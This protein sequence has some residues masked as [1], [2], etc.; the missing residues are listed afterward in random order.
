[1]EDEYDLS[2]L[3]SR[4]NPYAEKL[5]KVVPGFLNEDVIDSYKEMR[6]LGSL[7]KSVAGFSAKE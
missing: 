6:D 5:N 7:T 3:K 1:M 4:K 2:K